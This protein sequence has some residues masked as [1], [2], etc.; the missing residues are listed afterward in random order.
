MS[1]YPKELTDLVIEYLT[2]GIISPK[3][4][5]VLL[6]KAVARGVDPDEFDL[7]IEA[8]KQKADQAVDAA[9][10]KKR[11]ATCP[12]CGGPIPQLTEKCP[13]CGELITAQ[14]SEELQEILEQ[15]EDA[16]VNLKSGRSLDENKAKVERYSRKAELYYSHNPKIQRLIEAIKSE[17]IEAEE[18]VRAKA[19]EEM[20]RAQEKA[21]EEAR[22][23]AAKARNEA[24]QNAGR[25]VLDATQSVGKGFWSALMGILNYNKKV[26][27]G[28]LIALAVILIGVI[29]INAFKEKKTASNDAL[30]CSE[31]MLD[32]IKIGDLDKAASLVYAYSGNKWDL[33][34]ARIKL[35]EAYIEEGQYDLAIIISESGN[36]MDLSNHEITMKVYEI[37]LSQGEFEKAEA[38]WWWYGETEE[39]YNYLC[40]CTDYMI[41]HNTERS[42]INAFLKRK[43]ESYYPKYSSDS[44]THD[45]Q[46]QEYWKPSSVYKRLQEY[47]RE[48]Q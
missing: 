16:L 9:A 31:A 6:K 35:A 18:K 46:E 19:R 47:I 22:K 5:Q 42:K 3:E 25:G 15:L 30:L 28:V 44:W 33:K 24:L 7:Y 37:Y 2:D 36:R 10:S 32:A 23:A 40:R 38:L 1:D 21:R 14:A 17:T 39:Y 13:H 34:S 27:T 48:Q 26:T 4:R 20:K 8:Q 11:G 45:K 43:T 41:S 29:S 12:F